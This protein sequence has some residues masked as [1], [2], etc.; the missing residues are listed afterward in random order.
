MH[1]RWELIS[2]GLTVG[3]K[4]PSLRVSTLFELSKYRILSKRI[5]DIFADFAVLLT[6]VPMQEMPLA[7]P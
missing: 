6:T 5:G 3:R 2:L 4:S 7:L 1:G